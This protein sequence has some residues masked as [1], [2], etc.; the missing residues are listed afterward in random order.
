MDGAGEPT[1]IPMIRGRQI[2]LDPDSY[3]RTQTTREFD[4]LIAPCAGNRKVVKGIEE[5][6]NA[7]FPGS[8]YDP[9][10][11]SLAIHF[12]EKTRHPGPSGK[13]LSTSIPWLNHRADQ[14][15]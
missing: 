15:A 3:R 8:Q 14:Q 4:R 10:R 1:H 9:G 7:R 6:S 5:K 11:N 13:R 2:V 12:D